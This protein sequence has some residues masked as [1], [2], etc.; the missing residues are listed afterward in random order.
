M[1]TEKQLASIE[2]RLVDRLAE[3]LLLRLSARPSPQQ[4]AVQFAGTWPFPAAMA[5]R[6][7]RPISRQ[8]V[9]A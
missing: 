7:M 6:R 2:E 5:H 4:P 8:F 3:E 1:S 9:P